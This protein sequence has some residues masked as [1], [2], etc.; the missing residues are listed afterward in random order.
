MDIIALALVAGLPWSTSLTSIL[1]VVLFFAILTTIRT[2]RILTVVSHPAGALPLALVL[3][4]ATGVT[5]AGGV[6]WPERLNALGKMAK[7]LL[8]PLLLFHFQSSPRAKW[9]FAAFVGSNMI[10]LVYSFVASVM[11]EL[12][13]VQRVGGFGVP[14]RNYIDQ[15]QGFSLVAVALAGVAFEAASR[16]KYYLVAALAVVSFLFFANLAFINVARTAFFYLPIMLVLL[17]IR[18]ASQR[19]ALA[20]F[21]G[22][23]IL[24]GA[25]WQTSPNLQRKVSAIFIEVAAFQ[26]D[27][28]IGEKEPSA[29][30]RLEFWRKSFQFIESAPVLGHGT[31]SIRRLFE[32]ES[33]GRTGISALVVSN[34]HNQTLAAAVQW[35]SVGI[36]AVWAMWIAHVRLFRS[37]ALVAWIGMLATV[38]N[39]ASSMFNSHLMDAYEGWLYVL[40]VGIAGGELLRVQGRKPAP[41]ESA[42]APGSRDVK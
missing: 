14:V 7:L 31:G 11:P 13:I 22:V 36:L 12:A 16:Q 15:S 27:A 40:V 33:A 8:L 4:A 39:I 30:E 28:Q 37:R 41:L 17:T 19:T 24:C 25:L 2:E 9:M 5:W 38:Q 26:P 21:I 35:G 29:A 3:L 42:I 20:G 6:P 1:G 10:L 23:C 34:P 18:Y 32:Q